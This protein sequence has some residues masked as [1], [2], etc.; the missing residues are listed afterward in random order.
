[1]SS[2]GVFTTGDLRTATA[3]RGKDAVETFLQAAV[4]FIEGWK[5]ISR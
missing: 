2:N 1:M 3:K 4:K 5:A